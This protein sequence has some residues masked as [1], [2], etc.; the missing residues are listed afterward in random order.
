MY[1]RPNGLFLG[2]FYWVQPYGLA[3]YEEEWGK[4]LLDGV[5]LEFAHSHPFYDK[6]GNIRP[7]EDVEELNFRRL[8]ASDGEADKTWNLVGYRISELIFDESL[9]SSEE[10]LVDIKELAPLLYDD[11]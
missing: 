7:F 5:D 2:S 8:R 10:V 1:K 9:N 3:D 11:L 6:T 4:K